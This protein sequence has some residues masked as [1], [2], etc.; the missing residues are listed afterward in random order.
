[1]PQ[2]VLAQWRA[3]LQHLPTRESDLERRKRIDAYLDRG[4]GS[5]FLQDPRVAAMM[6][7]ALLYFDRERYGLHAWCVM[8]NH[9]HTLL[10]PKAS[11]GLGQ[12]AHSWKSFTAH[13]A[14]KLLNRSGEF[15]Q[16][17]PFDR[18]IRNE[19]HFRNAVAYIENNPVK[20]GL[21]AQPEDWL[22]SSA[23]W[24]KGY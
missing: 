16:T 20:A 13:E 8:P 24:R 3:E 12:I 15:W 2:F 10:T 14:N 11:W 4:Y 5:C 22:W 6:Q 9:V 23:R 19:Q 17:E 21:C 7:E 18:Y 1:M